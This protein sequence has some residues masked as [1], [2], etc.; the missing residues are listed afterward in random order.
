M[1]FITRIRSYSIRKTIDTTQRR[2]ITKIMYFQIKFQIYNGR[3]SLL[4]NKL[5]I[6]RLGVSLGL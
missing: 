6:S 5:R 4:L 2:L 3:Q 1:S